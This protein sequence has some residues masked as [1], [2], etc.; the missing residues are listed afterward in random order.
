MSGGSSIG[1]MICLCHESAMVAHTDIGHSRTR[2]RGCIGP[3]FMLSMLE[4]WLVSFLFGLS[5][6]VSGGP[7]G[8][9]GADSAGCGRSR[10]RRLEP[11]TK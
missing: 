9:G 6:S 5:V 4:K 2:G 1:C 11:S 10:G 7:G 8:P 3:C